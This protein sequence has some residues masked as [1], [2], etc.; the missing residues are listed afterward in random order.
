MPGYTYEI[1]PLLRLI[2]EYYTGRVG[3][4]FINQC[5]KTMAS[6]KDFDPSYD[7]IVD[8]S[9]AELDESC[10]DAAML[11]QAAEC[12]DEA[13]HASRAK[14]ALIVASPGTTACVMLFTHRATCRNIEIFSTREAA[15]N[16][17]GCRPAQG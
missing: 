7:I 6:D 4:D 12:H 10:H 15:E 8:F 2:V 5:L 3:L 17:I 9:E 11:K 14:T 1:R 16:W 13:H